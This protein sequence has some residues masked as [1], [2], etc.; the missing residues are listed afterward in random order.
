[1]CNLGVCPWHPQSRV[2]LVLGYN[3]VRYY[4]YSKDDK[5]TK[6]PILKVVVHDPKDSLIYS[7]KLR[8]KADRSIKTKWTLS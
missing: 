6:K 3:C 4:Y 7:G 5:T 2:S 1:M 8:G